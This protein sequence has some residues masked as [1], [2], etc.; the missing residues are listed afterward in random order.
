MIEIKLPPD[1]L[2][3]IA[4]MQKLP[5]EFPLAIKRGMDRALL[6]VT[7]RIQAKRLTGKGPFDP[8]FHRLGEVSQQ[9]LRTTRSEPAVIAS[10]TVTGYIGSNANRRGV[11]YPSIHE[12][13]GG[14]FPERSPFR[15]EINENVDYISNEIGVEIEK[16]LNL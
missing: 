4:R 1:T 13:G 15:T 3:K 2:S 9:L 11:S 14:K 6:I 10:N 7:G 12:Y 16:T 8:S 5:A